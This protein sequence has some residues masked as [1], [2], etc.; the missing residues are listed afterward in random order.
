M[1]TIAAASNAFAASS[2]DSEGSSYFARGSHDST[3]NPLCGILPFSSAPTSFASWQS[4]MK[5]RAW[6]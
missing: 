6:T 5:V 1:A 4:F 2:S 3:Q